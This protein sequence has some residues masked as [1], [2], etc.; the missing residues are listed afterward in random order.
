MPDRNEWARGHLREMIIDQR[1]FL[2]SDAQLD[3]IAETM[4]LIHGMNVVD[5]ACGQ[6][7]LGWTYWKYFGE[8]GS[9]TGIDCSYEL[10]SEAAGLAEDWASGGSAVFL[11]GDCYDLPLP[12]GCAD[13]AMCQTLLMHLEFP[14]KALN[15]MIRVTRPGGV[16]MCK[17]PDNLSSVLKLTHSSA[18]DGNDDDILMRRK[19]FLIWARGRKKLGKGDWSVGPRVPSMMGERGLVDIGAVFNEQVRLIQPPYDTPS[20]K[21]AIDMLRKTIENF[22]KD[23]DR[24]KK[25]FRECY[26]AGGGSSSTFYRNYPRLREMGRRQLDRMISQLEEGVLTVCPGSSSFLCITGR[27]PI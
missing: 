20:Q 9:Y 17:E 21:H 14:E 12:D 11:N 2:W 13:A 10:L 1:R 18:I 25:E 15:E 7:Y 3:R 6:G 5:I 8:G 16:I 4:G 26:I 27:K 24:W 23:E 22:G 19:M